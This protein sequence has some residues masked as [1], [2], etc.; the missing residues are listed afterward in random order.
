MNALAIGKVV[1]TLL[2]GRLSPDVQE[3]K[4]C[5]A[6]AVAEAAAAANDEW[7]KKEKLELDISTVVAIAWVESGFTLEPRPRSSNEDSLSQG[8]MQA[9]PRYWC[10]DVYVQKKGPL[11]GVSLFGPKYTGPVPGKREGCDL[12]GAGIKAYAKML[13]DYGNR[14]EALCHYNSGVVCNDGSRAYASKVIKLADKIK[15]ELERIEEETKA[16]EECGYSC[17][18]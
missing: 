11:N 16:T 3:E 15:K 1:L 5:N 8:I 17:G 10:R 12:L 4:K 18:C 14:R 2:L 13:H 6:I 9:Q 7:V